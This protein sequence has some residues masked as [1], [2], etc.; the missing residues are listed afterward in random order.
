MAGRDPSYVMNGIWKSLRL[1]NPDNKN[2]KLRSVEH[3]QI[4]VPLSNTCQTSWDSYFTCEH[5]KT[6][7]QSDFQVISDKNEDL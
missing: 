2:H 3:P 6:Q 1:K 5:L 4:S 7:K